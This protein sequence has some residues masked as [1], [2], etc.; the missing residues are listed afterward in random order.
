MK[1]RE[2]DDLL[3]RLDEKVN[4]IWTL[5]E[6]QEQHLAKI[7][8]HLEDHSKRLVTVETQVNERTQ[9]KI[10]KKAMA[11]ISGGTLAVATIV[12]YLIDVVFKL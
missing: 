4:N 9:S 2:R 5:T 6:K 3:I 1:P 11:G 8:G 10:S 12:Y 7:N